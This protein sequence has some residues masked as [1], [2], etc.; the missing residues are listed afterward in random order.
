MRPFISLPLSLAAL[1]FSAAASAAAPDGPLQAPT[2]VAAAS[3]SR[4][5]ADAPKKSAT[6]AKRGAHKTLRSS[7]RGKASWYGGKFRGRQTASGERFNSQKMTAAHRSLPLG[8]K[9]RVTNLDNRKSAV[10][11]VNDRLP[12]RSGR[13]IDVSKGAAKKLDFTKDGVTDV[14]V[15]V[16]SRPAA[17]AGK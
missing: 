16:L 9:V 11:K 14:Q 15:D 12:R 8:S 17:G 5:A 3:S 10:L 7:H 2:L 13:V 4:A 1:V 6:S